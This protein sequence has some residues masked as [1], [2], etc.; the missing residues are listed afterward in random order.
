MFCSE[1]IITVWYA[2]L[3]V[4]QLLNA[5][6][7]YH[8]YTFDACK[9]HFDDKFITTLTAQENTKNGFRSEDNLSQYVEV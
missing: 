5:V 7:E 6:L 3:V 2:Y 9:P 4:R 8:P 1:F